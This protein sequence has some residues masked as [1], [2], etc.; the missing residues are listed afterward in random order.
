MAKNT[1]ALCSSFGIEVNASNLLR[2]SDFARFE[3]LI[4][5]PGD[6]ASPSCAI[7]DEFH[8]HDRP[9]LYDTMFTG[10]G[11][12]ENPLMFVITTAGANIGG[13]CYEKRQEVQRMLAGTVLSE[14]LFGAI[15]TLDDGD[16]WT[17]PE[18]W[19]KA[20]PN[21]GVSVSVDYLEAQVAQAVRQP[22]KQN[23]IKCKHFNLW[24]GSKSA[25]LNMEQWKA[26]GDDDLAP[27]QFQR[28]PCY[29]GLD[30]ATRIDI[31]ARVDVF[32]RVIDGLTHYYAFPTF[33]LPE[34]ALDSAKNAQIYRGWSVEGHIR[35]MDGAE[36]DLA[37]IQDQILAMPADYSV[38][39]LAYDPWQAT[40]LAQAVRE[41]GVE[42]VEFRP[43]ARNTSAAMREIEAAIS[44]GRFH[45]PDNACLN[46]MAGNTVAKADGK[47][48]I[49][50]AKELPDNKIDGIVALIMAMGR[51]MT[52]E[53]GGSVYEQRGL[54]TL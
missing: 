41:Q 35:V 38:R 5:N 50:P 33:Y 29:V 45:H 52:G 28:D 31:A 6:G 11:A 18:A 13:P 51:A 39:E 20:N 15:W 47:D 12:R 25:W 43:I 42:T 24:T 36:V 23:A 40:Q 7:V 34:S 14:R 19:A 10:M 21:L 2:L 8:E 37:F 17:Q 49:Y 53:G 22:S 54:L 44:S 30:L 4:G 3:P 16:D 48:N 9:D 26:C 46:W 32:T 27:G 1:P